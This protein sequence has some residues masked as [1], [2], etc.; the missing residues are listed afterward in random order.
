MEKNTHSKIIKV[1]V[2][3]ILLSSCVSNSLLTGISS[4]SPKSVPQPVDSAPPT[5]DVSQPNIYIRNLYAIELKTF[6]KD[7]LPELRVLLALDPSNI[8]KI[9]IFIQRGYY[10]NLI[11]LERYDLREFNTFEEYID[12]VYEDINNDGYSDLIITGK[13][14][15]GAGPIGTMPRPQAL[16]YAGYEDSFS[17][18][19]D[20][21]ELVISEY[22]K[23][24]ENMV[25]LLNWLSCNNS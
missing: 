5:P 18:D 3:L 20:L 24:V 8:F 23:G 6:Y 13:F 17:L 7:D 10:A 14:S 12:M 25:E 19:I 21:M 15:T 4:P 9:D 1:F 2:L 22:D 11:K 16:I